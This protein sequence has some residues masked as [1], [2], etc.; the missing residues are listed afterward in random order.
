M[1]FAG[2][3]CFEALTGLID[4]P[5]WR[6][7]IVNSIC[8]AKVSAFYSGSLLTEQLLAW[9]VACLTPDCSPSQV[10]FLI[11]SFC[12]A[13]RTRQGELLKVRQLASN[14]GYLLLF[15]NGISLLGVVVGT[16]K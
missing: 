16:C 6:L 14:R 2:R 8:I 5:P 7:L 3:S 12:C 15:G 1:S 11:F 10:G 4:L 13:G 9:L